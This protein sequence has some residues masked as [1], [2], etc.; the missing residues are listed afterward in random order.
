MFK[1]VAI[2]EAESG[3]GD[4]NK[5]HRPSAGF[6]RDQNASFC[7]QVF[8]QWGPRDVNDPLR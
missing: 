2:T 6:S 5:V 4:D 1:E 7:E 3:K 8:A